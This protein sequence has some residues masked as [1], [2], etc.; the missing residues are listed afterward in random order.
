MIR[1]LRILLI[2]S[3]LFLI[4]RIKLRYHRWRYLCFLAEELR[5]YRRYNR[6]YNCQ[7]P[8]NQGERREDTNEK[9]A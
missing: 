2:G 9:K 4:T 5:G 8:Q 3:C 6:L 1:T 7:N